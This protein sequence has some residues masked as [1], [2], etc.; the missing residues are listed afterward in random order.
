MHSSGAFWKQDSALAVRCGRSP[1]LALTQLLRIPG[2]AN[3][4]PGLQNCGVWALSLAGLSP[5][6]GRYSSARE[7]G[8]FPWGQ[9]YPAGATGVARAG[10]Y[11]G[12]PLI[13]ESGYSLYWA[14]SPLSSYWDTTYPS[15]RPSSMASELSPLPGTAY[16]GRAGDIGIH[17]SFPCVSA[18]GV[19]SAEGWRGACYRVSGRG[20]GGGGRPGQG[21]LGGGWQMGGG[22]GN[23]RGHPG[24]ESPRAARNSAM[25]G[26]PAPVIRIGKSR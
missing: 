6:I 19:R 7:R 10:E 15:R 13:A 23:G 24:K 9:D 3:S 22:V 16:Q 11:S 17:G 26:R 1:G 14:L 5:P 2:C 4:V 18:R 21:D 20:S 12:A 8:A 25:R